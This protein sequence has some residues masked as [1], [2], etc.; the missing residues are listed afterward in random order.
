MCILRIASLIVALAAAF[1]PSAV[2]AGPVRVNPTGVNVSTVGSTTVFLT[3]GGL[4]NQRPAE[5]FWCGALVPAAPAIGL[6][7]DPATI[8]GQLPARFDQSRLSGSSG[9]TD[10]MS[11]PASVA[12]RAFEDARSGAS[13]SFFYVRRFVSLIGG[14][15]EFVAVTC[16]MAGGGA[17]A[18][19]SLT[20]VRLAFEGKPTV[21]FVQPG[22]APP[23]VSAEIMYTGTGRL[24]GRWEVVR[25][26]QPMPEDRDLLSEAALPIEERG[27]QTRYAELQRVDVFLPP[28]GKAVIP[29]PDVTRLPTDI[30]GQYLLLLRIEATDDKAGDSDLGAAGAGAGVV[31]S[32]AVAGF[33]MPVL[34]Y[35]VGTAAASDVHAGA[36]TLIA[37]GDSSALPDP[38]AVDLVW[39]EGSG[40]ALYRVE[41]QSSTGE[42][43]AAALVQPGTGLYRLPSW[44]KD[45]ITDRRMRWRVV[46]LDVQGRAAGASGWRTATWPEGK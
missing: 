42:L 25:P 39:R 35:V 34:R 11:I 38:S 43:V 27:L 2:L 6:R 29:G 1:P 19:F 32:G 26:G 9:F 8:F 28:V 13:S 44:V 40:A 37:P 23:A 20:D 45:K 16:R 7:C 3:F 18:P 30:E 41:V 24:R 14:P 17:R 12:R 21:Q 31:H 46:A 15:D 5:A 33:P 10:V 22:A 36:L 4:V